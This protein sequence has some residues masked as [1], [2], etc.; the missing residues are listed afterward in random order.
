MIVK[1]VPLASTG[2]EQTHPRP[3]TVSE[4]KEIKAQ[5][6]RRVSAVPN[7]IAIRYDCS[8]AETRL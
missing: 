6:R 2:F 3:V 7:L 1:G 4:I 8:K 5:F